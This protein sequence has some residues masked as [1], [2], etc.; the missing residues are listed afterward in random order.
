V[1]KRNCSLLH[2]IRYA[3]LALNPEP[4]VQYIVRN[5][6]DQLLC[7]HE[8][9]APQG[10]NMSEVD[11]IPYALFLFVY[12]DGFIA[13]PRSARIPDLIARTKPH[14]TMNLRPH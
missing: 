4:M 11:V 7:L 2:H 6:C 10:L 14:P 8:V 9:K 13:D 12:A 5:L 3:I 1:W